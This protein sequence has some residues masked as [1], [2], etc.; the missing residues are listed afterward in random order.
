MACAG[1]SMAKLSAHGAEIGRY[2]GQR[3]LSMPALFAFMEDGTTLYR[4]PGSGWRVYARLIKGA[5]TLEQW[6]A[7]RREYLATLP[8]WRRP[9][10]LPSMEALRAQVFGEAAAYSPCDE[11]GQ[12]EP[13]GRCAH[14]A[15]SWGRIFLMI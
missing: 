15:P 5:V 9:D 8:K 7:K 6:R 1:V 12:I 11:C 14:G 13:D 2:L 10:S 4:Q 3:K